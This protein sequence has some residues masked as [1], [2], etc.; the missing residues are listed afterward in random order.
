MSIVKKMS[1]KNW[2]LETLDTDYLSSIKVISNKTMEISK[3]PFF[4]KD[5][6]SN[7][8]PDEI[9]EEMNKPIDLKLCYSNY[10]VTIDKIERKIY[11]DD[12]F[13]QTLVGKTRWEFNIYLFYIK[14][15]L[16]NKFTDFQ[17][18]IYHHYKKIL[19]SRNEKCIRKK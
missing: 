12:F 7:L 6:K 14:I 16:E 15:Y 11:V 5:E 3:I 10:C 19:K 9:L 17:I 1:K 8:I 18:D 2:F 4:I 13:F